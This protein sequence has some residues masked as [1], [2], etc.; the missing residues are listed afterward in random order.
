MKKAKKNEIIMAI[1]IGGVCIIFFAIMFM[2]FKTIEET[3]ITA[4]QNMRETELRTAIAEWKG[5]YEEA[6]E[7][8]QANQKS[9]QEYKQKIEKNEETSDLI[10]KDSQESN[11]KVG[12]IN[13]YG[14]GIVLTIADTENEKVQVL[15]LIDLISELRYAGAEAI[16][17]NDV[18]ILSTGYISQPYEGITV[19]G[20]QRVSSPFVIKAIGNPTYLASTLSLKD[21]GYI[22][23]YRAYGLSIS[24]IEIKKNIEIVKD[25]TDRENKY[26]KEGENK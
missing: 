14:E 22:D 15:D 7:Q 19:I 25:N 20:G 12:K 26:I 8:L 21:S 9:I 13:V 1:I 2:Q 5:K 11:R 23:R 17:I 18:R 3:D 24:D 10:E 6:V 4:I 16:S